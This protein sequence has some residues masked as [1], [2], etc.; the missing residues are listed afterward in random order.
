MGATHLLFHNQGRGRPI[1]GGSD[2]FAYANRTLATEPSDLIGYWPLW[3]A[4][5]VIADNYEGTAARDGGYVGVTL[6]QPGIGDGNTCP[7]FD[8]AND[9][10]DNYSASLAG[11][12]DGGE[13][14]ALIW[15]KVSGVGAWTDSTQRAAFSIQADNNN[16][17]KIQKDNANNVLQWFY[18]AGGTQ[19]NETRGLVSETGWMHFGIT[20]SATAD[21]VI[22]YYNGIQQGGIDTGLGTWAGAIVESTTNIGAASEA[23]TDI[24]DGYL[25]HHAVWTKALTQ[26]QIAALAVV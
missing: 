12:F 3:E 11:A 9:Y 17:L 13:G 6:G 19:E 26:P 2:L 10:V 20:W 23:P 1:G 7:L 24:W 14:T 21:E 22:H 4:S 15:A 18:F 25:A 16:R 8:G 5:G